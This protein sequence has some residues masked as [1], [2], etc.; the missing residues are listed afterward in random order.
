[1]AWLEK[2]SRLKNVNGNLRFQP[3]IVWT[4]VKHSK[5]NSEGYDDQEKFFTYIQ[6][7]LAMKMN[8]MH[9]SKTTNLKEIPDN[10]LAAVHCQRWHISKQIS[11]NGGLEVAFPEFKIRFQFVQGSRI[12]SNISVDIFINVPVAILVNRDKHERKL[13]VD[14][15]SI[16]IFIQCSL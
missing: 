15:I 9:F 12:P 1:M 13:S 7:A 11:I 5:R 2:D 8:C 16:A 4:S 10:L 14:I 3:L 6:N